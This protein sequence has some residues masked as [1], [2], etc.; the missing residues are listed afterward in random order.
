MKNYFSDS[1]TEMVSF[2]TKDKD[3]SMDDLEEIKKMISE[4]IKKQKREENEWIAFVSLGVGDLCIPF[5][6]DL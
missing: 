2:F 4:E 6:F 1:Y 5:L 3:L